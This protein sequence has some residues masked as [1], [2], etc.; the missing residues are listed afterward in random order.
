[1]AIRGDWTT[2][3][4]LLSDDLND[5][6]NDKI[7]VS[8]LGTALPVDVYTTAASAGTATTVSRSDHRHTL[9]S[10]LGLGGWTAASPA[11]FYNLTLGSGTANQ[12]YTQVGKIVFAQLYLRFNSTTV[13]GEFAW[14]LPVGMN[15]TFTNQV[16]GQAVAQDNDTS[17]YYTATC[18][19]NTNPDRCYF[20]FNASP[21]TRFNATTPITWANSDWIY[22]G[23]TYEAE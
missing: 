3:E 16:I 18:L 7:S 11:T 21:A 6:V 23:V 13:S 9:S 1:M 8:A 20:H 14:I 17:N 15:T 2:N 19:A 10:S 12:R 4:V 22:V 5:T